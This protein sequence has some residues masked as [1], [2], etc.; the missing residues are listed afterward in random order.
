MGKVYMQ[1]VIN[2]YI[3]EAIKVTMY[4]LMSTLN[5]KKKLFDMN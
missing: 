4:Y 5:L 2:F 1:L 3:K